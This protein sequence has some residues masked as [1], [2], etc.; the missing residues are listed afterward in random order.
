M[1]F[2]GGT[3]TIDGYCNFNAPG[4]SSGIL[5]D[6]SEIPIPEP[7][8]WNAT[9]GEACILNKPTN[10][11]NFV[12]DLDSVPGDL[13]IPG[14]LFIG[15]QSSVAYKSTQQQTNW[16]QSDNTQVDY[17]LNKPTALSDFHNDIAGAPGDFTVVGNLIV[18]GNAD[19]TP[20]QAG[21]GV[22]A[23]WNATSGVAEILN[24]PTLAPVAT[25]GRLSKMLPW[26]ALT[27]L[28]GAMQVVNQQPCQYCVDEIGYVWLRGY[29]LTPTSAGVPLFQLPSQYAPLYA[30]QFATVLRV[31]ADGIVSQVSGSTNTY[32]FFS[33]RYEPRN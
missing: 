14:N 18:Q 11:T 30:Q 9:T 33:F 12:N 19:I 29:V 17:I 20:A 31:D 26:T 2:I 16:D 1:S 7:S 10:L 28:N 5:V 23:D 27:L 3:L 21:S 8:D 25:G 4:P 13:H 15:G 6:G 24:K 22:N 32:V